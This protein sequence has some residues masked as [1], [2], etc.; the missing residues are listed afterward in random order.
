MNFEKESYLN[1]AKAFAETARNEISETPCILFYVY[2]HLSFLI[3]TSGSNTRYALWLLSFS[4]QIAFSLPT[5]RENLTMLLAQ[6]SVA[7]I[8]L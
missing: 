5:N 3:L 8:L 7:R 1:V 4:I 2:I 6:K